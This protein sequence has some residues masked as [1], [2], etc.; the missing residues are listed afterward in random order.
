MIAAL[1]LA[2]CATSDEGESL[3]PGSTAGRPSLNEAVARLPG[4]AAGLQ[5]AGVSLYEQRQPGFGAGVDYQ[6]PSRAAVAT[7]YLYDRGGGAVPSDPASPQVTQEFARVIAEVSSGAQRGGRRLVERERF[8]LPVTG[9]RGLHCVLLEGVGGAAPVLRQVCLGG[10]GGRF[11]Q[12]Q[13]TMAARE[14]PPADARAFAVA[15]TRAAR[16]PSQG[17]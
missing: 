1:S 7:V 11:V 12:S 6:A 5:R 17:S 9:G 4:E 8:E 16:R 2:A 14:P 3:A 13:V 15:V 10:G